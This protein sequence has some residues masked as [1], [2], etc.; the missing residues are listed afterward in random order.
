MSH[1]M[2]A[3]N[4]P[5]CPLAWQVPEF[6]A[7]EVK[8]RKSNTLN[9]LLQYLL[10]VGVLKGVLLHFSSARYNRGLHRQGMGSTLYTLVPRSTSRWGCLGCP[11]DELSSLASA[12]ALTAL[13]SLIFVCSW[14]M[15]HP[16]MCG[17][18]CASTASPRAGPAARL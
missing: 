13:F 11:E 16:V 18:T 9:D 1:S 2:I 7:A 5:A 12:H 17:P 8:A 15:R 3:V 6:G 10:E 4:M 14:P